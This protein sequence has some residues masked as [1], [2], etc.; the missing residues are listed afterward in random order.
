MKSNRLT[1]ILLVAVLAVMLS[2]RLPAASP[3]PVQPAAAA[4]A[5][6]GGYIPQAGMISGYVSVPAAAF[7]PTSSSQVYY[8]GDWLSPG[9]HYPGINYVG[10]ISLPDGATIESIECLMRDFNPEDYGVCFLMKIPLLGPNIGLGASMGSA[11]SNSST[12]DPTL[13]PTTWFNPAQVDNSQFAY[14]IGLDL[15]W[16]D[17]THYVAFGGARVHYYYSAVYLPTVSK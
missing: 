17:A 14:S 6:P 9:S 5:A 15:P 3:T 2:G 11:H 7:H 10:E 1:N 8:N 4:P 16:D 13:Y 12:S